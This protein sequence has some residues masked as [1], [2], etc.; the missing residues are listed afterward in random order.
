MNTVL[1][2]NKKLCLSSGEIIKLSQG[3]SIIF[4]VEDLQHASPATVSRCGMVFLEARNLGWQS[5]LTIYFQDFYPEMLKLYK[6][7]ADKLS[8]KCF[9]C[10]LEF[11]RQ[12]GSFPLEFSEVQ[13]V[14][15]FINIITYL[16]GVYEKE[17]VSF[18]FNMLIKDESGEGLR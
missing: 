1:D 16:F 13:I 14:K 8:F 3:I 12:Y 11:I 9:E 6:E 7:Q 15:T 4:E 5:L 10:S 18:S 17:N 2:D